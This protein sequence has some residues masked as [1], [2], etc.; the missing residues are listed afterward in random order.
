MAKA[1]HDQPTEP[2]SSKGTIAI[3]AIGGLLVAAL[4]V[5]ALTRTVE[6]DSVMA[7]AT[8]ADATTTFTPP[9]AGDTGTTMPT[10]TTGVTTTTPMTATSSLPS[11]I[12][13]PAPTPAPQ[14]HGNKSDVRRIA[15]EDLRA[16]LGRNEVTVIDVRQAA[17]YARGHIPGSIN[18][19]L[20][21]IEAQL[22][23]IPKNKPIVTYCT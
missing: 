11:N 18:I 13:L 3:L 1:R 9:P 22:D 16:Q 17:D 5:W 20:A 4:V 15:A 7:T 19:P 23:S 10:A 12:S 2:T 6:P 8:T 21:S 14:P